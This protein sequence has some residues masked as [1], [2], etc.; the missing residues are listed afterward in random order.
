MEITTIDSA[1]SNKLYW[2]DSIL[3]ALLYSSY[4]NI[5]LI[6]KIIELKNQI[7]EYNKIKPR[8]KSDSSS[9][10]TD[11]EKEILTELKRLKKLDKL[12][13]VLNVILNM[14]YSS[15]KTQ[16]E[17]KK[18]FHLELILI[19]II[20]HFRDGKKI[21]DDFKKSKLFKYV[22]YFISLFYN[23]FTN[24]ILNVS[25]FNNGKEYVFLSKK[26]NLKE[27]MKTQPDVIIIQI[28]YKENFAEDI[29]EEQLA[30]L[31]T[32]DSSTNIE[33]LQSNL[34]FNGKKY[35][36]NS[37]TIINKNPQLATDQEDNYLSLLKLQDKKV[38]YNKNLNFKNTSQDCSNFIYMDWD[39]QNSMNIKLKSEEKQKEYRDNYITILTYILADHNKVIDLKE[40]YQK[41]NT[42]INLDFI[43]NFNSISESSELNLESSSSKK[44]L[45]IHSLPSVSSRTSRSSHTSSHS[46]PS[47]SQ[48]SDSFKLSSSYSHTSSRS[49]PSIRQNSDSFDLSSTK[50]INSD[51]S[52]DPSNFA[53]SISER[54]SSKRK[55]KKLNKSAPTIPSVSSASSFPS[56][57]SLI[58]SSSSVPS[59]SNQSHKDENCKK[60]IS[61]YFDYNNSC[62]LDSILVSLFHKYN[63]K[64]YEKILLST[65]IIHT[66]FSKKKS[67][68]LYE[69]AI[70]IKEKLTKIY[71]I[72]NG[73][74]QF[75]RKIDGS[76]D[77]N[78]TT[79]ELRQ[80]MQEY[81]D[82]YFDDKPSTYIKNNFTSEELDIDDVIYFLNKIFNFKEDNMIINNGNV[83]IFS[84]LDNF[85]LSEYVKIGSD[86][87]LN[88]SNYYS[89]YGD[90]PMF[91]NAFFSTLLIKID[92]LNAGNEKLNNI[93]I[94]SQ[95]LINGS[96][97]E[98]IVNL[99]SIIIHTITKRYGSH[100]TCLFKCNDK[101]YE[102]NDIISD[103]DDKQSTVKLIGTY[104]D[105]IA[106][107]TYM[108]NSACFVYY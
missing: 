100:Y 63:K 79:K 61:L 41:S 24:K 101:W 86:D 42:A 26:E 12:Y 92:R 22:D 51:V 25:S 35:N 102:Y 15:Y 74:L 69:I 67:Y 31:K 58:S 10:F 84:L 90:K 38:L 87:K 78:N 19:K 73:K 105:L 71:E 85:K 107:E 75:P 52:I 6:N 33:K 82:L 20:K 48:N 55:L 93:V 80:L 4:S 47:I 49:L 53:E 50:K 83:H 18:F 70:K 43:N 40:T 11:K 54:S 98:N 64:I 16:L 81:E 21:L 23:I 57:S 28:Q 17:L 5:F 34:I 62:Y 44:L 8:K 104:E 97:A 95:E 30:N 103:N 66:R 99:E 96:E 89:I 77:F 13:S 46:L 27:S 29:E 9:E 94:P 39:L 65:I 88:I 37:C 106:N 59:V 72:I 60:N 2:L 1:N 32:F 68:A 14:Q 76:F 36:L 56:I 108:R 45:A 91:R 3:T 7:T